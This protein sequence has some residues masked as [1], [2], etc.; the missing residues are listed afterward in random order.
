MPYCNQCGSELKGNEQF[1]G[2][3]GAKQGDKKREEPVKMPASEAQ[4]S[5]PP[6]PPTK[7]PV[8]VNKYPPQRSGG[9]G[10][11]KIIVMAVLAVG[12]I[13]VGVLYGIENSNLNK[14]RENIATLENNV[15]TLENNVATLQTQL[16]AEQANAAGL[17]TELT[18][19][20]SDLN[21]AQDDIEQLVSDI[22]DSELRIT[23]LETELEAANT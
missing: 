13:T 10:V 4:A 16:A 5:V 2:I 15:S 11:W 12:L 14:A 21:A 3:C 23:N 18:A 20:I 8:A 9:T 7:T 22:A 17:R 19:T 6:M 1:C